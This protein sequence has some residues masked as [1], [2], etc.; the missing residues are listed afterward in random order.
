ME[1]YDYSVRLSYKGFDVYNAGQYIASVLDFNDVVSVI[2]SHY[3]EIFE[4][5]ANKNVAYA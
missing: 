4:N 3:Q 2:E 1:R 5:S